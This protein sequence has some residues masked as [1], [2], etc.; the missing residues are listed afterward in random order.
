MNE[1]LIAQKMN[2]LL[3]LYIK[4]IELRW[5]IY[6][7]EILTKHDRLTL[8]YLVTKKISIA[9]QQDSLG[10]LLLNCIHRFG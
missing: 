6:K 5:L 9:C 7:K 3:L 2:S 1:N 10:S 4:D 8:S